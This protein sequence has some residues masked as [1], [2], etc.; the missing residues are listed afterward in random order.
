MRLN[1]GKVSQWRF[2]TNNLPPGSVQG[3][4]MEKKNWDLRS[5]SPD[6]QLFTTTI[7]HPTIIQN[8]NCGL[9]SMERYSQKKCVE[10]GKTDP[11]TPSSCS[12][13]FPRNRSL[14]GA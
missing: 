9:Y 12:T 11:S 3:T 8:D 4:K 13:H 10:R 6:R 5:Q 7:L 14:V 2:D 1:D